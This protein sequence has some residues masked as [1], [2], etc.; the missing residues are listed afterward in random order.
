VRLDPRDVELCLG[1]GE[2]LAAR[3]GSISPPIVQTSLFAHPSTASLA[4]ALADEFAGRV[5]SRGRNPTVEALEQVVAALEGGEAALGFGSGMGAISAALLGTL[6]AGDRVLFVN[7]VYGPTLQLARQLG[8]FGVRHEVLLET[9]P[10]SIRRALEPETRLVWF[11]SPG[12]MLFRQVDIRAL[13]AA[14]R[15]RGALTA[16]DNSWATP[17]LQKPLALGV[18]LVAHTC[19]KYL[20]GHSDTVAGALVGSEALLRQIFERAYLLNGAVLSPHDAWLTLRGLRTLP[21]R[22]ERHESNGLLVA[23]RLRAHPRVRRVF[24]P[25]FDPPP[26]PGDQLAG[27]SGL[28]SAELDTEAFADV[29]RFLD[30]LTRFRIGV[31]WGG[32]ESLAISPNRGSN[33]EALEAQGIPPGLVRLSVGLEPAESL[34][35]DLE[36]ALEA[37]G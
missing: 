17:L 1:H 23:E 8:R 33:A 7:Q 29:E 16:I 26:G 30:S 19:T 36:R 6:E 24:H 3:G 28:L 4:A 20:A 25:A 21:A 32:V 31:S 15:E 10:G 34:I 9:D 13:V 22:L 35:A 27:W 12:T 18:D 14:A 37:L 11:E 5:Y 2:D